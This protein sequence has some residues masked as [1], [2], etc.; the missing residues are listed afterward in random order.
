VAAKGR[1]I[2]SITLTTTMGPDSRV[3]PTRIHRAEIMQGAGGA[4]S[5]GDA[6]DKSAE[7]A[8]V[9]QAEEPATA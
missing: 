6:E 4:A 9:E 5:E 2:L 1:Y 7:Q 8:P 3:D